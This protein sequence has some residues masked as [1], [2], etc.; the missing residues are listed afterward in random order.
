MS[1][2]FK[3]MHLGRRNFTALNLQT[4]E[5]VTIKNSPNGKGVLLGN[6]QVQY[7]SGKDEGEAVSGSKLPHG[8][9]IEL[10][11]GTI[12]VQEKD[13]VLVALNPKL[14]SSCLLSGPVLLSPKEEHSLS[15]SVYPVKQIDLADYEWIVA[16]Y[17]LT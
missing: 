17:S 10:K 11:F 13:E 7:L 2:T 15:I 6:P 16:L 1:L 5:Q 12:H 9:L 4:E 8:R 14:A 3:E